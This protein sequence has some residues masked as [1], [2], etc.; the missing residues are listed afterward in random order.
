[1]TKPKEDLQD[2]LTRWGAKA[3]PFSDTMGSPIFPTPDNEEALVLLNETVALRAAMALYGDNGVGKSLLI[4]SWLSTLEPKRYRSVAITHATLS[5]IGLMASL[6][7]KLGCPVSHLRSRNLATLEEAVTQLGRQIPVLV[8]DEAQLYSHDALEEVRLLLGLSLPAQPL[9]ALILVGD[10]YLL[11]TLRLQS[12]KALYSRIACSF[13]LRPLDPASV[14][15]YLAQQLADVG[16]TRCCFDEPALQMLVA[17]ADGIP[18]TINL[19]ARAAW[20]EASRACSDI[21]NPNHLRSAIR[22]VPGAHDKI[23]TN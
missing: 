22:R 13:Q 11:D 16:I 3:V 9:F 7:L 18:R 19:V 5:G 8:L 14:E 4:R 12:R 1:M 6:L 21:I 17:A 2:Y 10:N 23:N 15:K 20:I